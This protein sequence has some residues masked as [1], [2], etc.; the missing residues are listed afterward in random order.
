MIT[1][2]A[3]G[4]YIFHKTFG[5]FSGF[6][7]KSPGEVLSSEAERNMF[8]RKIIT[9]LCYSLNQIPDVK[10]V[11][12]CKDSRSWRKDYK[13][14]RSVYKENRVKSEGVDWGSFFRLMDEFGV[15]LSENGFIYSRHPGAEGDD[16]VWSWCEHLKEKGECV[17]VLSGDK[18]M[19][20]LVSTEGHR[21]TGIWNTN[22]KNNKLV[23]SKEWEAESE[24]EPTIFDVTPI[25][26]SNNKLAKL[27]SSCTV[28]K[29]DPKE[30]IFKKILTGDKKDD[31]PGVF[32]YPM[33]NGKTGNLSDSKA[34]KIW[35]F[36]LQSPWCNNKIEEIWKDE[37]FLLWLSGL[38][39]RL[40]SQ[41]DSKENRDIFKNNYEE[42]AVLVWLNRET[43]PSDIS[44]KILE[45][46]KDSY[47]KLSISPIMDK[48]ILIEKSP[49]ASSAQPP[50]GF[51]PFELFT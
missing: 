15:F 20:Q 17:L 51:D 24:P 32:P 36:Y 21:W 12:F 6:G 4:N 2:V 25:S 33:K 13:I 8:L 1:V 30:F 38:S 35:D 26:G 16:L 42:N 37:D 23:V 10:R 34:Q 47:E 29:I 28:E 19:H 14:E 9:D 44:N 43:I 5:I 48:K 22:S 50:K 49:W 18:D 11:I 39:L 7:E 41:T 27:L 46:A 40:L 31:V 45:D 3:D